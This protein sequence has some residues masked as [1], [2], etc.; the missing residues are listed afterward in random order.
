MTNLIEKTEYPR[1]RAAFN[2]K[3]KSNLISI[4]LETDSK[5]EPE[6]A[7]KIV[8]YEFKLNNSKDPPR[9]SLTFPILV[10]ILVY[11]S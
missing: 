4:S 2:V 9:R 7:S 3:L 8:L 11:I 10:A 5:I 1:K 6:D